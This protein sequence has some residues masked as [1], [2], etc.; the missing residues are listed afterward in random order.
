MRGFF[1]FSKYK[2]ADIYENPAQN[3]GNMDI[4]P[5]I[6]SLAVR[7]HLQELDYGFCASEMAYLIWQ[8]RKRT[9]K[10]KLWAWQE[11]METTADEEV[12]S[13]RRKGTKMSLH[14]VLRKYVNAQK[15]RMEAFQDGK[16]CVYFYGYEE[17]SFY[18][19]ED[20]AD[21]DSLGSADFLGYLSGDVHRHSHVFL[22]GRFGV[23]LGQL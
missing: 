13:D 11:L 6:D 16:N 20:G 21:E 9:L 19:D 2:K 5:V 17:D 12:F 10:E 22:P 15:N 4:Y 3:G 14:H 7:E 8:S 23:S 18:E 1:I